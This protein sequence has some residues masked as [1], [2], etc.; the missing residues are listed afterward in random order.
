MKCAVVR[1]MAFNNHK[2]NMKVKFLFQKGKTA[3]FLSPSIQSI[4]VTMKQMIHFPQND[5]NSP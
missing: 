4:P 3:S 1:K 2:H 5:S